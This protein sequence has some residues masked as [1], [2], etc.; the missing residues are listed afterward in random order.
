MPAHRQT[1]EN[2]LRWSRVNPPGLSKSRLRPRL[3]IAQIIARLMLPFSTSSSS[4]RVRT[5]GIRPSRSSGSTGVMD[6]IIIPDQ[7]GFVPE[8][9]IRSLLDGCSTFLFGHSLILKRHRGVD[10]SVDSTG[11]R[12][13]PLVQQSLNRA[14]ARNDRIDEATI[15][16]GRRS[17]KRLDRD[18]TICLLLLHPRQR[19]LI[20]THP[21]RQPR[22][23]QSKQTPHFSNVRDG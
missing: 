18:S 7:M 6:I 21:L 19:R 3:F 12:H 1:S 5:R 10:D 22:L 9:L 15:H 13:C 14:T 23:S 11:C 2:I 16:G 4:A 8:D 17:L 20:H